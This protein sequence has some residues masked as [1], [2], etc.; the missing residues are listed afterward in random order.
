MNKLITIIMILTLAFSKG[1][2]NMADL[3]IQMGQKK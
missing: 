1:D 3:N 2:A